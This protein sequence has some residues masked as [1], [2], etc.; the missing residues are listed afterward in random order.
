MMMVGTRNILLD[1]AMAVFP[2]KLLEYIRL[3]KVNFIFGVS[4]IIANMDMLQRVLLDKLET[5]WFAGEIYPMKIQRY[6]F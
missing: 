3:Q 5:M 1:S 4:S 2:V 6:S